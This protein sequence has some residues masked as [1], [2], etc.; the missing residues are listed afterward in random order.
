LFRVIDGLS[1]LYLLFPVCCCA[2]S[3]RSFSS[4]LPLS[5]RLYTTHTSL[6]LWTIHFLFFSICV[7]VP[8]SER[9]VCD[10]NGCR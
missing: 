2:L 7:F 4:T 3:A 1:P 5:L 8:L 6:R 9:R 10:A